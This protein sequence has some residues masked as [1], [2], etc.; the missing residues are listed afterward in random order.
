MTIMILAG[1][2]KYVV[3]AGLHPYSDQSDHMCSPAP[4]MRINTS[5]LE[6]PEPLYPSFMRIN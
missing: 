3:R 2:G 1:D 4:S 6:N 5:L